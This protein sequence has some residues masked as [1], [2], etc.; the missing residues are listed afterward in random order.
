M[1]AADMHYSSRQEHSM[2]FRITGEHIDQYYR[3]GFTIFRQLMPTSLVT[4]MREVAS[5]ARKIAFEQIGPQAQRLQPVQ[6]Y[7]LD[8]APYRRLCDM[9]E[10]NHALEAIFHRTDMNCGWMDAERTDTRHGFLFEP[11]ESPWCTQWHRDWR[12]NVPGLDI[13]LWESRMLEWHMFNQVNAPLYED[14]CTWVVPGSHLRRDLPAE[15]TRFPQRPIKAPMT[16]GMSL[17]EAERACLDYTRSM[18]GATQ[19][20]LNAGDYMLYRST[21]WHIGNY[22]PYKKR[23]TL[24]DVMAGPD[25]ANWFLNPPY[26]NDANGDRLPMQNPNLHTPEYAAAMAGASA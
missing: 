23:A 9:D 24:H 7:G 20:Q 12:D 8:I 16:Q 6:R 25:Y 2:A 26:L 5:K 14:G 18:P 21:L 17:A 10:L 3:D 11:S 13:A 15:I 1:Q 19:A 4:E 22:L